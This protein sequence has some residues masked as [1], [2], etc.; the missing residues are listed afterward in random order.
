MV[1]GS[2]QFVDPAVSRA[3]FDRMLANYRALE[4]QYRRRG[5]LLLDADF[6]RILVAL[7]AR[8]VEPPILAFGVAFDYTNYDAK[9]AS[10]RLV[11]PFTGEPYRW[12]EIANTFRSLPRGKSSPILLPGGAQFQPLMQ[13]H[14][15]DDIPFLCHPGVRE[16]HEH[17][18]HTGDAWELH[19]RSG[20]G[21][22]VDLLEVIHRYGI[23]TIAGFQVINGQLTVA[24]RPVA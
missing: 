22:L 12:K 11:N 8:Q 24:V 14:D 3:K 5:W 10:V 18:G 1:R 16:Y 15:P 19:R 6:P 7:T 13:A 4:D 21:T 2:A 17:P 20:R 23:E 9:P